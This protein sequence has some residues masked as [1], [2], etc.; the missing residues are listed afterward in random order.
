MLR[1]FGV[2]INSKL[3]T[4][5]KHQKLE[6]SLQSI[7]LSEIAQLILVMFTNNKV[8]VESIVMAIMILAK[9]LKKR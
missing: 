5:I 1:D 9:N 2:G 6:S 7:P 4:Q 3:S 8:L